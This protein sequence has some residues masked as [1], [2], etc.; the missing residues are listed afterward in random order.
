MTVVLATGVIERT[1]AALR[2]FPVPASSVLFVEH[3]GATGQGELWT[4]SG[5]HVRSFTLRTGRNTLDVSALPS[6]VYVLR[7]DSGSPVQLLVST[8]YGVY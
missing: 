6:G 2:A 3:A 5:Q 4:A 1:T 8:P 7:T